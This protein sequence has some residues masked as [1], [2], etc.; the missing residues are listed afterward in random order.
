[1]PTW[2]SPIAAL[3]PRAALLGAALFVGAVAYGCASAG[4]GDDPTDRGAA[5]LGGIT[6]GGPTAAGP[7]L[8]PPSP[9]QIHTQTCNG[10][11]LTGPIC[12]PADGEDQ[13]GAALAPP[14]PDTGCTQGVVVND[15]V[16]WLCPVG[17][18][19]PSGFTTQPWDWSFCS[20]CIGQALSPEYEWAITSWIPDGGTPQNGCGGPCHICVGPCGPLP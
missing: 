9:T 19:L 11:W 2:S 16:M 15:V 12:I 1:V 20:N 18:T 4:P 13:C 14:I 7:R 8:C 17:T 10:G 3:V 5:A 6:P